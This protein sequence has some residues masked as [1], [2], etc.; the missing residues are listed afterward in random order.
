M[1]TKNKK[2]GTKTSHRRPP[3]AELEAMMSEALGRAFPS[4]PRRDFRHQE[5]FSVTVG[6]DSFEVDGLRNWRAVGR[7]DIILLHQDR[8]LAVVELKRAGLDLTDDDRR[9]GQSYANQLTPRPP[10]V[11]VTNGSDCGFFDSSTGA[12]WV[13]G[14]TE[15]EIVTKLFENAAK[16]AAANLDWAIEVLMGP[17]A[18][19]WPNAV[20][21]RTRHVL[22]QM[23]GTASAHAKP[24]VTDFLI[25]RVATVSVK[26]AFDAGQLT[27]LITGAPLSG[28]SHILREFAERMA[29]SETYAVFLVRGGRGGAGLFQR[30]ANTLSAALEWA[31]T[32]DDIRQWLRRLSRSVGDPVLVLAIDGV[33]PDSPVANDMEELSESGFGPRLRLLATT[34]DV[35][36]LL[37]GSNG[38]DVTALGEAAQTIQVDVLSQIEFQKAQEVL[39]AHRIG[40]QKGADFA[41]EYRAPWLLRTL[42]ADIS[43]DSRHTDHGVVLSSMLGIWFIDAVRKRFAGLGEAAHGFRLLARDFVADVARTS[44]ELAL[45]MSHGFVVRRDALQQP[46]RAVIDSLASQGWLRSYRHA[47]GEDVIAPRA[48]DLF[49]SEVAYAISEELERQVAADP[50]AAGHWLADRLEGVFLGDLIGAQAIRDMATRQGAF[51][52]GLLVGLYDRTPRARP[53][54]RG[55]VAFQKPDGTLQDLRINGDGTVMLLDAARQ[56]QGEPIDLEG[57][58]PQTYGPMAGWMILAQLAY[59]PASVG[60]DDRPVVGGSL[61]LEIGTCPFPLMRAARDPV[62]HL[63]HDIAGHG[64]VLCVENGVVEPATS[65]MQQFFTA[66]WKDAASWFDEA[67]SRKSLPLLNRILIALRQARHVST[68]ARKEWANKM[69]KERID[70]AIS[71]ILKQDKPLSKRTQGKV[72]K[73]TRQK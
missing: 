5:R 70:P 73:S 32:A 12:P 34:D 16:I 4:V 40:F 42:L 25:P 2:E 31:V 53:F 20:R 58:L 41:G 56:P 50:R 44:S 68:G 60:D 39:A 26:R 51:S 72:R 64:S 22:D 29:T 6:H 21:A 1:S 55:V 38:R 37:S 3:E 35:G 14:T 11:I 9:Q 30:I 69:L 23:T 24:F 27:L 47:G 61:L 36:G 65:A 15:G 54:K 48:P 59:L 19:V 46:T 63:V 10:L 52:S 62:G 17:D 13:P 45:E 8:P 33:V 71:A 43:Q 57:E 18:G 28:K 66:Q 49:L 67:L 7:A